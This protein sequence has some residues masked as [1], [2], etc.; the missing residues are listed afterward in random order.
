[1]YKSFVF[2]FLTESEVSS[3]PVGYQ[4]TTDKG[5][6]F[7]K[8]STGWKNSLSD[9]SVAPKMAER[10]ES[11]ALTDIDETNAGSE[12]KIGKTYT[13]SK[14]NIYYYTGDDF[15]TVDGVSLSPDE[16][17]EA[18]KAV[19]V[20]PS[21]E[22]VEPASDEEKSDGSSDVDDANNLE[23][24]NKDNQGE[25]SDATPTD[26]PAPVVEPKKSEP[27]KSEPSKVVPQN[28]PSAAPVSQ[29]QP[30]KPTQPPAV[31]QTSDDAINKL[32]KLIN[33]HP[34]MLRLRKL[35]KNGDPLSLLAADIILSGKDAKLKAEILTRLGEK[36]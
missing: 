21:A 1:M 28:K 32:V 22:P 30:S 18:M 8:S 15:V 10:L 31:E 5:T 11:A 23:P 33:R 29:P 27:K 24:E 16:A 13:D 3:V 14:G 35:I 9:K 20:D 25:K 36:K 6:E 7:Y 2:K 19:R 26:T 17:D 4:Y 12:F 34:R